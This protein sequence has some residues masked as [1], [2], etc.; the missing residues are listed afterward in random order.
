MHALCAD[1]PMS[2]EALSLRTRPQSPNPSSTLLRPASQRGQKVCEHT[3]RDGQADAMWRQ[4]PRVSRL[5]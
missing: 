3:I 5:K 1:L 4:E 2:L